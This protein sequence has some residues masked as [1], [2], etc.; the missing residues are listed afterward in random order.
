MCPSPFENLRQLIPVGNRLER[1]L[2]DRSAGDNHPVIKTLA[3][4]IKVFVEL[5]HMLDRSMFRGMSLDLHKLQLNLQRRIAEQSY[6]IGFRCNL[7][8]HQI[9]HDHTQRTNILLRC[10]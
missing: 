4:L 2:L 6:E 7:Q 8:R 1:H 3:H 9:E 5:T 10:P